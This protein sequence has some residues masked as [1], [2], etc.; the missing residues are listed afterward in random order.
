M[1]IF[2]RNET[3]L[4][5]DRCPKMMEKDPKGDRIRDNRDSKLSQQSEDGDRRPIG[6]SRC[7]QR[8][9]HLLIVC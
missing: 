5:D 7:S 3:V 9:A 1:E 4:S 6:Y 8:L 2:S